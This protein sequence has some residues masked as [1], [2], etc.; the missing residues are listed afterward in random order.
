M[1]L[2]K[3]AC[4]AA[5]AKEPPPATTSSAVARRTRSARSLPARAMRSNTARSSAVTGRNGSFCGVA[6]PTPSR[7]RSIAPPALQHQLFPT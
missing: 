1:P 2:R 7:H 3:P 4:R 5:R 6:I